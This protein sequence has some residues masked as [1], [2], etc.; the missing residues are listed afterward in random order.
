MSTTLLREITDLEGVLRRWAPFDDAT[1]ERARAIVEDVRSR[2]V[3]AVQ[4]YGDRFGELRGGPLV[5]DR[6]ALRAALAR[7]S[8]ET[9]ALL[10]RAA[11][12]IEEFSRAQRSSLVDVRVDVPGGCAGHRV[13][14]LASAGCYAPGGRYPLPSSVLMTV[15]PARVAGV[16]EVWVASPG[17]S[18]VMLAAA[19]IAGA[20]GVLGVGGAHA[21]AALAFGAG[22]PACDCVV[23]PG[24]AYVTAAK[25]VVSSDVRIDM[26]AGPS[27]ILI[28]AD[29]SADPRLVA[30]DMLAQAE[31]DPQAAAVL[32]TTHR[33][34]VREVETELKA[35]LETL[36]TRKVACTALGNG[37]AVVVN[38][39]D[40]AAAVSDRIAP[41]HVELLTREDARLSERL[42]RYG[43][44]FIGAQSA[45]V[46]GDYGLGPNHTL[47]TGGTARHAAGLSVFTFLAARTWMRMERTAP[48]IIR[49]SA[50]MARLE[51]LEGHARSAEARAHPM[52]Q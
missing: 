48:E 30:A 18:D 35:Q 5:H 46:L 8:R 31:H 13:L 38:S 17:P 47:P 12:R 16:R 39:L 2:G 10:E 42:T 52:Q 33:P 15:I 1:Y 4:E 21:V 3:A 20:D 44:L 11:A 26:L 50:A 41:E 24:N 19:A 37:F 28:I 43:T 36:P 45:E 23:G 29:D 14:P 27:E 40:E 34:L 9:V 49:D 32:V 6:A 7:T 25:A 51:G 22:V